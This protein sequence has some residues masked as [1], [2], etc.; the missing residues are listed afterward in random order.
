MQKG[1]VRN[2][3]GKACGLLRWTEGK[4]KN[5]HLDAIKFFSKEYMEKAKNNKRLYIKTEE[6][7]HNRLEIRE[8]YMYD[9]VRKTRWPHLYN[10]LS[11]S[12]NSQTYPMNLYS[13]MT[14][15]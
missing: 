4:P 1:I 3:S 8:Y 13:V 12:A 11:K 15:L 2:Y 5:S 14:K 6:Y 10:I 7:A 9:D